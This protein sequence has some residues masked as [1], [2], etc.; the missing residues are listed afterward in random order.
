MRHGAAPFGAAALALALAGGA[1]AAELRYATPFPPNHLMQK[2]MMEA[3]AKEIE[4]QS[5]GGLKITFHAGGELGSGPQIYKRVSDGVADMGISLQGFTSD[6]FPRS[7]LIEIPGLAKDNQ[8]AARMLWR[9]FDH[10]KADYDKVK[11][12]A[13]FATGPNTF[14]MRKDPLRTLEDFKGKRLRTPSAFLGDVIKAMG[15]SPVSMP[16]NDVY[17]AMQTGVLDG[18]GT[19]TSALEGFKLGEVTRY[20]TDYTAGVS[21]LFI[22]MNQRSYDRLSP[23]HRALIDKTTGLELSLVGAKVYDE[24]ATRQL[25]AE[26]KAGRGELIKMSPAEEKRIDAAI[27][28]VTEKLLAEREAKGVPARAIVAAMKGGA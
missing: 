27:A 4:T 18:A 15:A 3:W 20:Y 11:V 8:T 10:I 6:Q 21:P 25:E 22:V 5:N 13:L 14:I 24:E 23:E 16:I 9:A 28:P 2:H 7:L 17:H 19:G 26:I 1:A 12:I